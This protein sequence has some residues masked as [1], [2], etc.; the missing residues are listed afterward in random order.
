MD[1][2]SIGDG[3]NL[4]S[5]L[6]S[7]CKQYSARILISGSTLKRLR[8]TY[9]TRDIDDVIVKG[10]TEPVGIH[11]V[12]DYHTPTR[13]FPIWST[14]STCSARPQHY[15]AGSFERAIGYFQKALRANPG[16]KLSQ[17]YIDRCEHLKPT[18]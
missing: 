14:W 7:L 2:T 12:L 18:R 8:G 10:K 13:A 4:A 17:F 5:R 9:R 6:E 15:K 11:E 1:Y 3:V 16:D